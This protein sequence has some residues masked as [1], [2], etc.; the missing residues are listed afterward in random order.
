MSTYIRK[1]SPNLTDG[2][3][4]DVWVNINT[5]EVFT[6]ISLKGWVH[7]TADNPCLPESGE[8]PERD[9]EMAMPDMRSPGYARYAADAL[10]DCGEHLRTELMFD[11]TINLKMW[12]GGRMSVI[13][14]F[15]IEQIG[16]LAEQASMIRRALNP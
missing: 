6:R 16:W 1:R 3:I 2:M 10:G 8:E 9:T 15:P 14:D 11:D 4:G 13:Q 12:K 5:D 7:M